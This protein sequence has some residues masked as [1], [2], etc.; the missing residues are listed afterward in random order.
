MV[1]L[2]L[3]TSLYYAGKLQPLDLLLKM[4]WSCCYNHC[5]LLAKFRQNEKAQSI[6][7]TAEST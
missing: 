2:A 4:Q 5:T 7:K 1:I 3:L 6:S